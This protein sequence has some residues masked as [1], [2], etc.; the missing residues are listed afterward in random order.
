MIGLK[1]VIG[2]VFRSAAGALPSCRERIIAS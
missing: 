1:L 2:G